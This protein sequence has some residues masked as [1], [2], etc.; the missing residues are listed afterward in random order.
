MIAQY[1]LLLTGKAVIGT[2][3]RKA[4][5]LVKLQG[6][7]VVGDHV[8]VKR[9]VAV[10]LDAML[11][12]QMSYALSAVCLINAHIGDIIALKRGS[13]FNQGVKY[14]SP[15]RAMPWVKRSSFTPVAGLMTYIGGYL[16]QAA[17]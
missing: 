11:H 15:A 12:Q 4:A 6:R 9:S 14:P 17:A 5:F 2:V 3:D 13:L 8:K 7:H 1:R 10:F 16:S